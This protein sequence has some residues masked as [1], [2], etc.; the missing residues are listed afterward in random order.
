MLWHCSAV[1]RHLS[2]HITHTVRFQCKSNYNLNVCLFCFVC[3]FVCFVFFLR[4]GGTVYF[5]YLGL[6]EGRE[7]IMYGPREI[8]ST[9]YTDKTINC[10]RTGFDCFLTKTHPQKKTISFHHTKYTP[11]TP[12]SHPHTPRAQKKL[13]NNQQFSNVTMHVNGDSS[14]EQENLLPENR[15]LIKRWINKNKKSTHQSSLRRVIPPMVVKAEKIA[16]CNDS[17]D[18]FIVCFEHQCNTI[19]VF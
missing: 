14:H 3:L 18:Y 7:N 6:A 8:W 19:R 4:G 5:L 15:I 13:Q 12:P 2:W 1:G 9:Q 16:L 17:I 11:P 10:P